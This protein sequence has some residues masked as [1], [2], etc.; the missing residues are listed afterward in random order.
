MAIAS[1]RWAV[2]LKSNSDGQA[3]VADIKIME[4]GLR[5]ELNVDAAD[6]YTLEEVEDGVKIGMVS[7]G[8]VG[9][10]GGWGFQDELSAAGRSEAGVTRIADAKATRDES[11]LPP[12]SHEKQ[13]GTEA[14]ARASAAATSTAAPEAK[15][16]AKKPARRSAKRK[17]A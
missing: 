14:P 16:A 15:P 13:R 3:E 10:V 8:K 6:R 17:A 7:G 5:P 9:T 12:V 4:G 11:A 2:I 1:G